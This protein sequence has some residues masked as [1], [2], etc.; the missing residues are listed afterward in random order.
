MGLAGVGDT[1]AG[2]GEWGWSAADG[3][4]TGET[5]TGM[6]MG[7]ES[8]AG[9]GEGWGP[10]ASCPRLWCALACTLHLRLCRCVGLS[11]STVPR[12]DRVSEIWKRLANPLDPSA[13]VSSAPAPPHAGLVGGGAGTK[14]PCGPG[15]SP[16][17]CR[18]LPPPGSRRRRSGHGGFQA[19]LPPEAVGASGGRDAAGPYEALCTARMGAPGCTHHT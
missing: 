6:G 8:V 12:E 11:W 18:R 10:A 19:W 13:S 9:V 7:G 14:E 16:P 3:V 15:R 4:G 1:G 17:P 5:V 2:V